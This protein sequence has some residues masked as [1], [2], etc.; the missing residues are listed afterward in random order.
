MAE[1]YGFQP[2]ILVGKEATY[3]VGTTD[4]TIK[5]FCDFVATDGDEE[6]AVPQK[7]TFPYPL[8]NEYYKG[9]SSPRVTLSGAL[10][11]NIY[12]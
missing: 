4:P 9:R 8:N 6:I 11:D 7:T 2:V 12:K 10:N 5:L 3:A 1:R